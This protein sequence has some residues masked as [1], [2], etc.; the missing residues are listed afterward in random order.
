MI[1]AEP[2]LRAPTGQETSADFMLGTQAAEGSSSSLSKPWFN[3]ARQAL[4]AL[5]GQIPEWQLLAIAIIG[6]MSAHSWHGIYHDGVLYLAQALLH[7]SPATFGHDLFFVFG[8]QDQF[9]IF[10]SLQATAIKWLGVSRSSI[11]LMFVAHLLWFAGYLFLA[12]SLGLRRFA[13]FAAGLAVIAM[14][15]GYGGY[16]IFT[17][18][19]D[20]LTARSYAEPLTLFALGLTFRGRWKAALACFALSAA[21]HPLMTLPG[22]V[23]FVVWHLTGMTRAQRQKVLL[24]GVPVLLLVLVGLCALRVGPFNSWDVLYDPLWL[25]AA[26]RNT[27]QCFFSQWRQ[28]DFNLLA[29]QLTLTLCLLRAFKNPVNQRVFTVLG[30]MAIPLLALAVLGSDVIHSVLG[31]SLQ[32]WRGMWLVVVLDCLGLILLF[33]E[34]ERPDY[35]HI[36]TLQLVLLAYLARNFQISL[37]FCMLGLEMSYFPGANKIR[38]FLQ[39]VYNVIMMTVLLIALSAEAVAQI[40]YDKHLFAS[41]HLTGFYPRLLSAVFCLLVLLLCYLARRNT[42]RFVVLIASFAL[43]LFVWDQRSDWQHATETNSGQNPFDQHIPRTANVYWPEFFPYPWV[44]LQRASYVSGMSAAAIVFN[45]E[46][47]MAYNKRQTLTMQVAQ[48]R[49]IKGC[50]GSN[51]ARQCIGDA[52]TFQL[53]CQADPQI[54][55]VVSYVDLP[56]YVVSRW[57]PKIPGAPQSMYLYDCSHFLSGSAR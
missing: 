10:A 56:G 35:R 9:T 15:G 57:S 3:R 24:C 54:N 47:A 42:L 18:S 41:I 22:L 4:K 53:L 27:A 5:P 17:I 37:L 23:M 52:Q 8:S 46:L 31:T 20:F 32:L 49:S 45:R 12:Y 50:E 34:A 29:A 6:W 21:V 33:S 28:A 51:D 43:V 30:F 11:G 40:I 13:L 36:L 44:A 19:E 48:A 25:A 38:P 2:N 26:R 55:F 1:P 16:N 39:R 7:L 14:P